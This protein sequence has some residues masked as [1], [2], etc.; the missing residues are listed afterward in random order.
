M[1]NSKIRL[2]RA[3]ELPYTHYPVATSYHLMN[4]EQE[5]HDIMLQLYRNC[6]RNTLPDI[7]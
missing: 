5:E 2:G 1:S 6:G 7:H 3:E 4:E